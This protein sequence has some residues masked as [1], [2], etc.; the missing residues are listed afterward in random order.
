MCLELLFLLLLG[1]RDYG[2][3]NSSGDKRYVV[4]ASNQSDN[5][6]RR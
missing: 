1:I 5:G 6:F 4:L 3:S 2:G